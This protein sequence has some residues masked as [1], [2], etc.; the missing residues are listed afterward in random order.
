VLQL[1]NT[2][3]CRGDAQLADNLLLLIEDRGL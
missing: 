1:A 2:G 3:P